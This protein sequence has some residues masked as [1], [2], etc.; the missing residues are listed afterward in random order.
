MS[1]GRTACST[2]SSVMTS[3]PTR[4]AGV[5]PFAA[6]AGS[7]WAAAGHT[8]NPTANAAMATQKARGAQN[9]KAPRPVA[10]VTPTLTVYSKQPAAYV[11]GLPVP[12]KLTL[13]FLLPF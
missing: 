1:W 2:S 13:S 8:P 10:T 3:S 5:E 4:A 12:T 9:P 11:F 7:F 6:A